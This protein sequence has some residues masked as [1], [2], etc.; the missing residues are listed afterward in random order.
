MKR[1]PWSGAAT[2]GAML[3]L[4]LAGIVAVPSALG[5]AAACSGPPGDVNGDGHADVAIGEPGDSVRRGGVHVLY[6]TAAGLV[7]DATDTARDDQWFAKGVAG[8]PGTARPASVG[9]DSP[10][11]R[12]PSPGWR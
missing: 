6:G 9:P 3:L 5:A 11:T 10:P 7:T 12:P 2:L 4:T 1:L 8:V